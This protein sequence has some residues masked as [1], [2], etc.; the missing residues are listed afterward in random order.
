MKSFL[1]PITFKSIIENYCQEFLDRD[2]SIESFNLSISKGFSLN[3]ITI[4]EK[5][6]SNI[7]ELVIK[8]V[9]FHIAFMDF[10]KTKNIISKITFINPITKIHYNNDSLLNFSD[11][12]KKIRTPSHHKYGP[13][14]KTIIIENATFDFIDDLHKIHKNI[15][16][17]NLKISTPIDK[18]ITIHMTGAIP[19]HSTSFTTTGEYEL[20][21]KKYFGTLHFNNVNLSDYKP[22]LKYANIINTTDTIISTANITLYIQPNT[23]RIKGSLSITP[24]VFE[25]DT[26]SV[27]TNITSSNIDIKHHNTTQ[28]ITGLIKIKN[29]TITDKQRKIS[30]KNAIIDIEK[31]TLDRN[32]STLTSQ[33]LNVEHLSIVAPKEQ[34]FTGTLI[35]PRLFLNLSKNNLAI[36]GEYHLKDMTLYRSDNFNYTGDLT[37]KHLDFIQTPEEISITCKP[38]TTQTTLNLPPNIFLSGSAIFDTFKISMNN[39][40]QDLWASMEIK[41]L[42]FPISEKV[43]LQGSPFLNIHIH[44]PPSPQSNIHYK[45]SITFKKGKLILP[46][47]IENISNMRGLIQFSNNLLE[48]KSLRFNIHEIPAQVF[49]NLRNFQDPHIDISILANE[50]NLKKASELILPLNLILKHNN[51]HIM[52]GTGRTQIEIK[53]PLT[54]LSKDNIYLKSKIKDV[55]IKTPFLKHPITQINGLITYNTDKVTWNTMTL[56]HSDKKYSINGEMIQNT[57]PVINNTL[58]S[59]EITVDSSIKI[60]KK[61][62]EI[63]NIN[64]KL[65]NSSFTISGRTTKDFHTPSIDIETD[66]H[67][68]LEDLSY[69]PQIKKYI[70]A[71]DPKGLAHIKANISGHIKNWRDLK[72]KLKLQSDKINI[73]DHSFNFTDIRYTQKKNTMSQLELNTSLYNGSIILL[74]SFDITQ[75][76]LPFKL[77]GKITDLELD[78]FRK[79]KKLINQPNLSGNLT[80]YLDSFGSLKQKHTTEGNGYIAI[81]NGYLGKL[82]PYLSNTHFTDLQADFFLANG[83]L[84]TS[85]GEV[86]GNL[87]NLFVT[88]WMDLTRHYE[89]RVSQNI[90]LL[91]VKTINLTPDIL[92]REALYLNCKG[93]LF[94]KPKCKPSASPTKLLNNTGNILKN[95]IN[96][97]IDSLF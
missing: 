43:I 42:Y 62:L 8:N 74:S 30:M 5:N 93:N 6:T 85:N 23:T 57:V 41:D 17:F 12:W 84:I 97:I 2:I 66:L 14:Y 28:V 90:N 31:L 68:Y 64:G 72:I 55:A 19:K 4:Y 94:E 50:L 67:L 38:E 80:F 16:K 1:L 44:P 79:S 95:G 48:T 9:N 75:E 33:Q 73:A 82:V 27:K 51:F 10:I 7:P 3:N 76:S 37:L 36:R 20:K 65:K 40:R 34:F 46:P 45:G 22:Y 69:I 24:F 25:N 29:L 81:T 89:I 53:G 35:S 15:E 71:Y 77:N 60:N 91:K 87:I 70:K 11:I 47:Y 83:R 58:T 49:G 88:G 61:I 86:F 39:K 96:S 21:D 92:L 63:I 59:P 32:T 26:I 13:F 54:N 56:H 78:K 52:K 18:P